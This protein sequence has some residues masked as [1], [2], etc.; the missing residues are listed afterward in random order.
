MTPPPVPPSEPELP[1]DFPAV[2][3]PFVRRPA[4]SALF[5]DFD[6]TLAPI[7]PDPTDAKPV[8]G[9]RDLLVHLA[10]RLSLVAV[11]SGRPVAYLLDTLG[12]PSG[13]RLAGLY[14]ME[15]V[16]P[17]GPTATGPTAPTA[18]TGAVRQDPAAARWAPAVETAARA[19]RSSV[20]PGAVVEH[21]GLSVTLHWRRAPSAEGWARE[22]AAAQAAATG[23]AVQEGRMSIELRPPV[24][25]D[26][27]T[28]VERLA[29][30]H[31]VVGFVGDDLGDLPAF[32]VLARLHE[33]GV[34]IA[35][36]AV[37]DAESVAE[38][39]AAADLVVD[40]PHAAVRLLWALA[41]APGA[42]GPP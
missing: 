37:V 1:E 17:A 24:Q 4:E 38:V 28:V 39:A 11:V 21:K 33:T 29:A 15:E 40:G 19:A 13:V 7:V 6:G 9:V 18:P 41:G 32:D 30:G 20:P 35:R 5:L 12:R 8:E 16:I 23:L 14:G 3:V 27:G 34:D 26:K 25:A 2:L 10:R 42:P 31:A 22:T 36:V